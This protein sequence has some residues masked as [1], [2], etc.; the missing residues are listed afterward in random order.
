MTG[1]TTIGHGIWTGDASPFSTQWV[2]ITRMDLGTVARI[3]IGTGIA[4]VVLGVIMLVANRAG[5]GSLP[6]DINVKRGNVRV[7]APITSMIV[8]SVV[9][10]ILLNV[11]LRGR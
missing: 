5:L 7:F 1:H 2:H 8:V 6:G 10:T 4:L 9:L 3:V 11:F